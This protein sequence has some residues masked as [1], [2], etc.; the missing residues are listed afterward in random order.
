MSNFNFLETEYKELYDICSEMENN[1]FTS[2][3]TVC[4]FG[5][6]AVET[7]IKYI[8]KFNCWNIPGDGSVKLL[9]TTKDFYN[10][11]EP[12]DREKFNI[13]RKL[14]NLAVHDISTKISKDDSI[15]VTNIVFNLASW[16]AYCYGGFSEDNLTFQ[17]SLIPSLRPIENTKLATE[18]AES[19]KE[20]IT[21][22]VKNI[23][24]ET[25]V[26]KEE[27]KFTDNSTT[28]AETRKW[29]IDTMLKAA[30]W[31]FNDGSVKEE[32]PV[33]GMPIE[34][35]P[36]GLGFVDYVLF[37]DNGKPLAVVEAKKTS[38]DPKEGQHQAVLY[39]NCL[40]KQFGQRPIIFYSNGYTTYILNDYNKEPHRA[41][42]GFY[43]KDELMTLIERRNLREPLSSALSKIDKNIIN[44]A[45][46][47]TGVTKVIESFYDNRR[48]ALLV[49]ATGSGKTRT[50]IALVKAL[51]ESQNVKRV[52]FLADRV[53]LVEQARDNFASLYPSTTTANVL[54]KVSD[55]GRDLN[56]RI[57]F[58][59][60]QS[61]MGL[62]EQKRADGTDLFGVGHFDLIIVD[63]SHRSLYNK[64]GILFEYFDSMLL[65]LTATPKR[66]LGINT[67]KT[68][69]LPN[70]E[71]THSYDLYE[72]IG[73]EYLVPPKAI[74][75][76]LKLPKEGIIYDELSD[77]EK[78]H[79]EDLFEDEDGNLPDLIDGSQINELIK[80]KDT[81]RT[82]LHK[83][84]D[85]GLKVENGDKLGKTIIF[86]N[87]DDNAELIVKV[88]NEEYPHL[89]HDFCV[90]ITN[91]VEKRKSL[92]AQ[93]K[94][95]DKYPQIAVSVDMLDT[96]VDIP[97][98]LNL[99]FFRKVMS[100]AK[101]WQMVG[102]GTRLCPNVF[103][104]G[105]DKSEF[106][107]FDY[108]G[109]IE[110]FRAQSEIPEGEEKT[111]ES[112]TQR[113]FN[114]QIAL[115]KNLQHMDYQIDEEIKAFYESLLDKASESITSINKE[116]IYYRKE[117]EYII[118]YSQKKELMTLND[119]KV[120]EIKRHISYIPFPL[121][122]DN[123]SAKWFDSIILNL[124]L[125]KFEKMNVNLEVKRCVK[126]GNIL[127][128]F[129]TI[130]KIKENYDKVMILADSDRLIHEDIIGLEALR[131]AIRDLLDLL[132]KV[133]R[134]P[135]YSDFKDTVVKEQIEDMSFGMY[136]Y[137]SSKPK[138][139]EFLLNHE[140]MLVIKKLKNNITI[141]N[142][143]FKE[144]ENLL[145]KSELPLTISDLENE[146]NEVSKEYKKL[147][148]M[149]G[150]TP[151]TYFVRSL[152]GLE[153]E[154][155]N[156]AFA[157]FIGSHSFTGVQIDLIDMI[158][159][160]Y[161]EN[162]IFNPHDLVGEKVKAISPTGIMVFDIKEITELKHIIDSINDSA[163]V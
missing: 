157:D 124:Q 123:T 62:I 2:P 36:T 86:T 80:N 5:R 118:K 55:E 56:A 69:Q 11:F 105:Q 27:V 100:K 155:V 75:I 29:Y 30:G 15:K 65:G 140:N 104:Q 57:I 128:E 3:R 17:E 47:Q 49:M 134:E 48:K 132:P 96:G 91:K 82:M 110:F 24:V 12:V 16:F 144:L 60:Y 63:E 131:V 78:E 97:E 95:K 26:K 112:M 142:D 119:I 113:I 59:T 31:N 13:V 106:L 83:L 22:N 46:Q 64:F 109:N 133:E 42:F 85:N 151:L 146:E 19:I 52:L 38:R 125:S 77:D 135:I 130:P 102:R 14:G 141:D 116:S 145:F 120:E 115:L 51:M 90:K 107:I 33:T 34:D 153:K 61:M 54:D 111:F 72:A 150:G 103:G 68:F 143:D 7:V 127:K 71:P 129:G 43:R 44:R 41:I 121:L 94:S 8:Y 161:I 9:M 73:D 10:E 158:K 4:I 117:K 137:K 139:R 1:Y 163:K 122:F 98:I 89:G 25:P 148:E 18:K 108:F 39:A 93:L 79:Y 152:I 92:L 81:I 76:D 126:I 136:E 53:T 40:E 99:V 70:D 147:K 23:K 160:N 35:N 114:R 159:N 58:S 154:A 20:K 66:E 138:L 28:E 6:L 67:F 50:A 101:F 74:S 45:Y 84:M 32:F 88:F 162:G 156:K 37:G 149:Y 87:R 21:T